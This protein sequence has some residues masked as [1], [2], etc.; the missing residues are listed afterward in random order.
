VSLQLRRRHR[1]RALFASSLLR[2]FMFCRRHRRSVRFLQRCRR[3]GSS[4]VIDTRRLC[5]RQCGEQFVL[6][7]R[8]HHRCRVSGGTVSGGDGGIGSSNTTRRALPFHC[9]RRR[10]LACGVC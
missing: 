8:R 3:R 2:R 6:A 5:C 1:R 9:Q 4:R 7:L 10:L